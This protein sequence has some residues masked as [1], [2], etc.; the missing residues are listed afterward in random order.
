MRQKF[1]L[2]GLAVLITTLAVRTLPSS[3]ASQTGLRNTVSASSPTLTNP[4]GHATS[5]PA[6]S[7]ELRF[8]FSL[9]E[10]ANIDELDAKVDDAKRAAELTLKQREKDLGPEDRLVGE[11]LLTLGLLYLLD[12]EYVKAEKALKRARAIY[13]K[14]YGAESVELSYALAAS[15]EYEMER[16]IK[17]HAEEWLKRSLA[18]REKALGPEHL[19]VAKAVFALAEY[20][21][22]M[23]E[24]TRANELYDRVLAIRAK[25]LAP[26][27]DAVH[28][29]MARQACILRKNEKFQE[30]AELEFRAGVGREP[31]YEKN[32]KY[33]RPR[34]YPLDDKVRR[35]ARVGD[36]PGPQGVQSFGSVSLAIGPTGRAVYACSNSSPLPSLLPFQWELRALR[37]TYSV[38]KKNGVPAMVDGYLGTFQPGITPY[39]PPPNPFVFGAAFTQKL[40][41]NKYDILIKNSRPFR[42]MPPG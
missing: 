23:R 10:S 14:A 37:S 34:R 1:C 35:W 40:R 36:R 16:G 2:L 30:A 20:Y 22:T 38:T 39:V 8:A 27:D 33:K 13:E 19:E 29:V 12:L 17:D 5:I 9:V 25:L 18:L 42:L 21:Q 3:A 26:D 7:D 15:A 32:G 11:S 41:R 4:D 24:F 6:F 31:E 28:H